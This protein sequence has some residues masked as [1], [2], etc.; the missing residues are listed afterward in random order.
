MQM[1]NVSPITCRLIM[2]SK[3]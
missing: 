1:L 3:M 2:N